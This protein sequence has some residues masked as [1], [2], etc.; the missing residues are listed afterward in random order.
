MMFMQS[1][2]KRTSE[3]AMYANLIRFIESH[4]TRAVELDESRI[5][6]EE[7]YATGDDGFPDIT[8]E[9]YGPYWTAIPAKLSAAR[10]F[11]GY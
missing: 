9:M 2:N 8:K 3:A 1:P 11:L 4:A 5:L 10:D 7:I 6:V